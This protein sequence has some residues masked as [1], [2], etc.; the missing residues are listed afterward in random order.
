MGLSGAAPTIV[1]PPEP[2]VAPP[3]LTE[4][5]P[6]LSELPRAGLR[7]EMLDRPT[8]AKA[9]LLALFST[10]DY[11]LDAIQKEEAGTVAVVLRVSADG[12]VTDC[13]VTQSSNSPSLDSQTCRILW[14][15]ARFVPAKD[16]QGRP[17]ES[18]W[19]QRI[20]WELPE[21][22]PTPF[23][24]W[25]ARYTLEFVEDGGLISCRADLGGAIKEQDAQ[26]GLVSDMWGSALGSLRADAGYQ[27]RT[28]VLDT[29]FAPGSQ[30]PPAKSIKGL[31]L[32]GRQVARLTVD[33]SGKPLACRVVEFEGLQPS[34]DG[35]DDLLSDTYESPGIGVG[36]VEATMVRSAYVGEVQ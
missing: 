21:P 4:M 9:N 5:S 20:R 17:V 23:K 29:E 6:Y 16:V 24:P 12:R 13:V 27:R 7:P 18:A 32:F 31:E 14:M 3:V 26:C 10:Q 36:A 33:A 2:V 34:P 22:E 28:L 35:C 30:I 25:S 8:P 19:R 15:R 1:P 11:P